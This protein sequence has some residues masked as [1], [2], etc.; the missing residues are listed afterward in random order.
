MDENA[1][2]CSNLNVYVLNRTPNSNF[3]LIFTSYNEPF[4]FSVF[5]GYGSNL[6]PI[7]NQ[8]NCTTATKP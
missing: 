8:T 2:D 1:L 3:S 6:N 4:Y 7:D 5:E